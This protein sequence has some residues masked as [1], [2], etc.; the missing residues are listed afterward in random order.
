MHPLRSY[1]NRHGLRQIH[2]A[3][4]MG[5]SPQFLNDVL[6]GRSYLGRRSA[7]KAVEVTGGEVTLA[8]LATWT[9]E[10]DHPEGDAA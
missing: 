3:A 9:L 7:L 1:C 5:I 4:K 8:D 6:K 10:D 2:L